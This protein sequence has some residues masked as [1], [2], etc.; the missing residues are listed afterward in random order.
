MITIHFIIHEYFEGPG[1]LESWAISKGYKVLYSKLYKGDK[2]PNT[3]D[4]LD[5]LVV[6]GGPQSPNTTIQDCPYFDSKA[7]MALIKKCIDENKIVIGICL[8]AQMIGQSLGAPVLSSPNTEIGIFEICKTESGK[9]NKLFSHLPNTL[10]VGHWHGDMANLTDTSEVIAYSK[11]CPNQIIKYGEFVYGFQCH[12]EFTSES[13]KTLIL[14]STKELETLKNKT[15]VQTADQIENY[16]FEEMNSILTLFIE[17]LIKLHAS[18]S[19]V[20]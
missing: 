14:N 18:E 10:N 13:I 1:I 15:Y 5:M 8:G 20:V 4:E 7:E 12:L 6:M 19:I 2:L 9:K 3:T 17:N 11:G 16:N